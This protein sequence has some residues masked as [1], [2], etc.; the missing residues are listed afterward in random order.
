MNMWGSAPEEDGCVICGEYVFNG[1]MVCKS[2]SEQTAE[3]S[4]ISVFKKQIPLKVK[5]LGGL[6][7]TSCGGCGCVFGYYDYSGEEFN[8][9]YNC[10]QRL[11][12]KVQG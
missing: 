5:R 6:N 10:G 8:Y 4:Y 3:S 1:D 11:K 9:C 7:E 2:C 12:W